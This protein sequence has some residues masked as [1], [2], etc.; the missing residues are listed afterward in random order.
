M[1]PLI[2]I[3]SVSALKEIIEDIVSIPADLYARRFR[4]AIMIFSIKEKAQSG[5]R[6]KYARGGGVERRTLGVDP[7]A[8]RGCWRRG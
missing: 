1:V 6:D 4:L 8:T 7:M 5:R 3:L 2:F